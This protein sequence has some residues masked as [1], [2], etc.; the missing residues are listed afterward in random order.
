LKYDTGGYTGDGGKHEPAGIVHRGEFVIN[1]ESTAEI[2]R[3]HPGTLFEM[4]ERGAIP[5]YAGGGPVSWPFPATTRHAKIPTAAQVAAVVIPAGPTGGG[6]TGPWIERV[7]RMMVPAIRMISGYRPGARTLSGAPSMHGTNDARDFNASR[8]LAREW[9][10]KYRRITHE[11]ISPFQEY[12]IFRGRRHRYAGAV[13]R[14]HNFG[15]GNAHDHISVKR[16][17]RIAMA[18]GGVIGEPVYGTGL[19][20]GASYSFAEKGPEVVLPM[21]AAGGGG[22]TKIYNVNVTAAPLTH[23]AEVGRQV[24]QHIQAYE[25][26]SGNSWREGR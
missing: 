25:K 5:G 23:P 19:R 6:A 16:G 9:D 17:K 11:L 20:S 4:N 15:G 8:E 26:G 12:N 13:W 7:A 2:E 24:V 14:Q 10:A 22:V 18:T 21:G 1:K 3:K